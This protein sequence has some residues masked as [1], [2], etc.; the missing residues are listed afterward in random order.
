MDGIPALARTGRSRPLVVTGDPTALDD[1][2]RLAAAAGVDVD[3]AP[4]LSA[5]ARWWPSAPFVVVGDDATVGSA[6]RRLPRRDGVV[7]LGDDLD[8]A[9]VWVRAVEVGAEQVAFLP[10]AESW[11]VRRLAESVE[12]PGRS[13]TVLAVAGGRGG[14]G[15]TTLAVGLAVTA[16]RTGRR[17]LLVDADPHGGGIDL[18]F[19]G[20]DAPGLRWPDLAATRGRLAG[21]ALVS[22]LPALDDV[23]V[24]SWDRGDLHAVP[25][26]SARAVLAAAR[27]AADVVVVD[28]PRALDPAARELLTG[29]ATTLLVVPA[30]VR[31]VAAAGRVA[32]VL[33]GGCDDVRVVVRGPSPAGLVPA[34][35]AAT[36]GLPLAGEL[37]SEDAVPRC[38]ER[39]EPPAR[40][41][42]GEL[43][44][45]SVR[46]LDELVPGLREAA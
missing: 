22:A 20:E 46:L 9:G 29:V 17:A 40:R 28:L 3:V 43:W 13:A 26:E 16:V 30:E 23:D 10:D 35:V 33:T 14:A 32:S 4:D 44:Q 37:A 36:L 41:G 7:L 24:L 45:L 12:P 21:P 5:A 6:A 19:G 38:L 15:A 42:R 25:P 11:L 31:A 2:L 27:S 1:L 18:V 34:H 39:G 8:D